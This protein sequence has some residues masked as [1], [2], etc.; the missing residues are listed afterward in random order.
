[1]TYYILDEFDEPMQVG[2]FEEFSE[3]RATYPHEHRTTGTG[4]PM[5]GRDHEGDVYVSTW[6]DGAITDQP[7][8]QLFVTSVFR[9][10]VVL[11]GGKTE[12]DAEDL[13]HERYSTLQEAIEGHRR[14]VLQFLNREPAE[15]FPWMKPK[16][17]DHEVQGH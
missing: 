6:F 9:P 8:H 11:E 12:K 14:N 4:S 5:V 3:W 7:E 1:M 2:T 13:H 15:G 17:D 10:P 16:G